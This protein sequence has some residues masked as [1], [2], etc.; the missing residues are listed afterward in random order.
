DH[1]G[2]PP[3]LMRGANPVSLLREILG[4]VDGLCRGRGG[5]MHLFAPELL[6]ASSGIVGATGP[7]AA[8]FAL[9]SQQLR[10]G[11][12][13]VAFFGEAA[14]NEGALLEAFNLAVAWRLPVLFVCKDNGWSITTHSPSMTGGDLLERARAF[15]M[16]AADVDGTDALAVYAMT[17][18]LLPHLRQGNGPA[19]LLARC[20]HLNGHFLGDPLLEAARRP[21][22]V[23]APMALPLGRSAL[24]RHG[25]SFRDRSRAV[26][27]LL[28]R[29]G[30]ASSAARSLPDPLD[31]TR[32]ALRADPD[33]LRALEAAV[34][35]EVRAVFDVALEETP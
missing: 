21:L 18:T 32:R 4:R 13:A 10:P 2:T 14:M 24:S 9:A 35:A 3:L 8:G 20:V 17:E 26:T 1:R 33:R 5:H 23:L 6:S 11:R 29:A 25:A 19:F 7:M 34:T 16:P 22:F 28:T 15:G 30:R 27:D 31:R 12:V